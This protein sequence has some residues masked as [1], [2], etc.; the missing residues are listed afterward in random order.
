MLT[1]QLKLHIHVLDSMQMPVH[2][3]IGSRVAL[4]LTSLLRISHIDA[5]KQRYML[6]QRFIESFAATG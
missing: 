1:E 3:A 4:Q 2:S 6:L 5:S